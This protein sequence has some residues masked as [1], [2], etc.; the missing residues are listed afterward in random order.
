M[1]RYLASG[2][3]PYSHS[4]HDHLKINTLSAILQYVAEHFGL[5]RMSY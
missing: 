2:R 3:T 5:I 1:E 4:A